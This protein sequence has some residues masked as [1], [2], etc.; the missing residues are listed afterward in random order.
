MDVLHTLIG[1]IEVSCGEVET[2]VENRIF[3]DFI[4]VVDTFEIVESGFSDE[5]VAFD[6]INRIKAG[7]FQGEDVDRRC[8]QH[9]FILRFDSGLIRIE[10]RQKL[11]IRRLILLLLSL[12]FLFGIVLT[13]LI[14]FGLFALDLILGS[15]CQHPEI[16]HFFLVPVNGNGNVFLTQ[17]VVDECVGVGIVDMETVVDP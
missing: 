12:I 4:V 7:N 3:D 13:I 1:L 8:F 14:F 16:P 5:V 15:F 2:E 6:P 10:K 9:K 17:I 11:P